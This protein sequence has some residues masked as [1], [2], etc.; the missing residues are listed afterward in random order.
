MQ[1]S[2]RGFTLLELLLVLALLVAVTAMALPSI[3]VMLADG[4]IKRA[5]D[6]IRIVLAETRLEAMRSGRT[7]IFRCQIGTG[8]F[9]ASPLPSAG[10]MTE[11][12]D[13][14]GKMPLGSAGTAAAA[15][16]Y[17]PPD[18][19]PAEIIE[20]PEGIVFNNEQVENAQRGMI[21]AQQIARAT[22]G[23]QEAWSQPIFFYADGT[24]STA[25]VQVKA[26]DGAAINVQL[27]GLTGEALVTDVR[28]IPEF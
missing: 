5:G 16:A 2:R 11:A 1:Q 9:S 4:R 20:L 10:D 17:I 28:V 13:M 26:A 8:K 6:Q 24:T 27:R 12:A 21:N 7:H 22:Q 3:N 25:L 19:T 18:P 23:D 15:S 14:A